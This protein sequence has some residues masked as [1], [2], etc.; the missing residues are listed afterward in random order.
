MDDTFSIVSI[1]TLL[2]VVA[3][4]GIIKPT[5]PGS[6]HDPMPTS[7]RPDWANFPISFG[8]VLGGVSVVLDVILFFPF[9]LMRRV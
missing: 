5:A 6:L 9:V 1:I 7:L 3:A 2:A 8:L 4:D